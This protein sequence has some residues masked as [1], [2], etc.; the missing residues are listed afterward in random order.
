M[1][2]S[3]LHKFCIFQV[4]VRSLLQSIDDVKLLCDEKKPDVFVVT[5]S[6]LDA[7]VSDNKVTIP[8][9]SILQNDRN[10]HS[11]GVAVYFKSSRKATLVTSVCR[12]QVESLWLSLSG[13]LKPS[14]T[15]LYA[16]Y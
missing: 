2:L 1:Y 6:W 14:S 10:R 3:L 11:G 16:C 4:N 5:E 8:D 9:Y 15:V 13:G 7:S 12:S